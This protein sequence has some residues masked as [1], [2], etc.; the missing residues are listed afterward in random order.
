MTA[1]ADGREIDL[2]PPRRRALLALLLVRLGH[3][4]PTQQLLDEL[5]GDRLPDRAL[6]SL[7]SYISH[8]RRSL[9]PHPQPG[10]RTRLIRRVSAGYVLDLRRDQVDAHRF[11]DAVAEGRRLQRE[12]RHTEARDRLGTALGWWRGT[13]Y[14]ELATDYPPLSE[15]SDRL[16]RVR[17]SA[18]E[19][20]AD[21]SLT[22]GDVEAVAE[23]DAEVRAHPGRERLAGQ[24]M[25]AQY[26]LGR[27]ADAL[28]VYA[29]T[30]DWLARELGVD[31]GEELKR[32]HH[33]ILRQDLATPPAPPRPSRLGPPPL[34]TPAT[35]GPTREAPGA[36]GGAAGP[37]GA[38]AATVP[39]RA[40]AGTP[41]PSAP[42]VPVQP[43]SRP[44]P[45]GPPAQHALPR[46]SGV[47][48]RPAQA[49]P[50]AGA[51]RRPFAGREHELAALRILVADVLCGK[52]RLA[53]V[54][55]EPGIGKSR[56]LGEVSQ[57]LRNDRMEAVWGYCFPGRGAP[58]YWLWTQVLRQLAASRPDA[59]RGA[60][61]RF[62]DLLAPLFDGAT[63][64]ATD[65]DG[66][67]RDRHADSA[68]PDRFRTYD[69][70]CE[71]L[72]SLADSSPL[73]L[74]LEDLHWAD[75]PSL[76]LL[77]L[78]TSRL[79]GRRLGIV[80]SARTWEIE[81]D[82]AL[83]EALGETLWSPRTE[84][85]RLV[86]LPEE[87][88]SVI[89][90]AASG[91]GVSRETIQRLHERSKGNPYFVN[92]LM[93]LLG[94]ATRLHDPRAARLM[95]TRVPSGVREVLTQRFA[96]LPDPTR[97]LLR[98]CAVIGSEID[99]RL[100]TEVAGHDEATGEPLEPA[101]RA[102]LLCED[103]ANPGGL[104][105]THALVR[106]TLYG[107][108]SRHRRA[109]LHAR[110]AETLARTRCR[111]DGVEQL[112]HH[113][114]EGSQVLSPAQ[115]LPALCRAAEAAEL[116]L[117]YEQAE[118]WLRRAIELVRLLPPGD[119]TAPLLE[120][121][122]QIQLGQMLATTRGYGDADAEAAFTRSR[123]LNPLTGAEDQPTVLW[124][125]CTANLV[126]GRYEGALGFSDRLRAMPGRPQD[127]VAYLGARYG[128]GIVLHVRGRLT[129]ALAEL[130]DAVDRADALG[131][132]G[133]RHV[134]RYFQHDPRISCRSYDA[135]THWLLGAAD[136]ASARRAELLSLTHHDSRPG[137]RAF[138]LYVDAVLAGLEGDVAT[139]RRSGELGREVA[140]RYGLRYW[141][142]M[143]SV[144]EGWALVH[145]GEEEPGLSLIRSALSELRASGTLIRL[146]LHLG[147]LAEAL[148]HVGRRDEAAAVLRRLAQEVGSR[149]EHAYLHPR[150]PSTSLMHVLQQD[151]G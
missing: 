15:E 119:A 65:E 60:T 106:E 43:P 32:L 102:Q 70:V 37:Q 113:A 109:Q 136:A 133:G 105:F 47:P 131:A 63:D 18:I 82:P 128:R 147:F 150:L 71:T 91:P 139:A 78:L 59:F 76:Q 9:V 33:A 140:D 48:A 27:Q 3:V 56:L 95:L 44:L 74:L 20:W 122:L 30:R 14:E 81:S 146:P 104:H 23:L 108:L 84:T 98:L 69:A 97:D 26:R 112:A 54:L 88:V 73:L 4:V 96:T 52:G 46:P 132:E 120:Q 90:S 77:R 86:G 1:E 135:F 41:V 145:G 28:A 101:V 85:V 129:E 21:A 17:L 83:G 111:H 64:G 89:V 137:D 80:I 126:T 12:R 75:A 25:T 115:A 57:R 123:A 93:S 144:C 34:T 29:R 151:A 10:E 121:Q 24:V 87:A 130:E 51:E 79:N 61:E 124:S 138:A 39:D 72:L 66:G 5:W 114:W 13:P 141:R 58:P 8:L 36:G 50:A 35:A 7:H 67:R 55:G 100:L 142:S 103:P 118:M 94:D 92:Q 127:P 143:L 42:H 6:A 45:G 116:R 125:L 134:A 16:G 53:A 68:A 2:G 49:P 148:H 31:A 40:A 11:E 19:S 149:G 117:A 38:G 62:G 99:V 110:V 107:E 22:L